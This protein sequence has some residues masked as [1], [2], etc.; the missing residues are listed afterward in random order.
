MKYAVTVFN[1]PYNYL[2]IKLN[3]SSI[4][5]SIEEENDISFT[6]LISP[7]LWVKSNRF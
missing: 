4:P 5:L 7:K 3:I 2:I 6:L 1:T